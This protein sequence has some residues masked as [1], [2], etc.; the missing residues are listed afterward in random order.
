M[1]KCDSA[2]PADVP[3]EEPPVS[4]LCN[5][6]HTT[7]N[8]FRID[9]KYC[10]VTLQVGERLFNCHRVMLAG[11]SGYFDGMFGPSFEERH[12]NDPITIHDVNAEI[13][14]KILNGVYLAA[15]LE[16]TKDNVVNMFHT[17]NYLGISTIENQCI[18]YI[19]RKL[20][21]SEL[22]DDKALEIFRFACDSNKTVLVQPLCEFIAKSFQKLYKKEIFQVHVPSPPYCEFWSEILRIVSARIFF[23][24]ARP[25]FIQIQIVKR[26]AG[27]TVAPLI[28]NFGL[29]FSGSLVL[30]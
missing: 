23:V 26:G 3:L 20:D 4:D 24:S 25:L 18:K 28:A 17:S 13:F 10:D 29:K 8:A 11:M 12:V 30:R 16:I 21:S 1:P 27:E 14:E 22:D 5:T 9:G 15:Q 19:L 6:L 7:L 2:G